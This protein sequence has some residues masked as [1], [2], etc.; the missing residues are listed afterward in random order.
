MPNSN[1]MAPNRSTPQQGSRYGRRFEPLTASLD[2]PR[3]NHEDSQ[4]PTKTMKTHFPNTRASTAQQSD[5]IC[6]YAGRHQL[7]M[8]RW[9]EECEAAATG[10]F[11]GNASSLQGVIC[12]APG[13][14]IRLQRS[15][16]TLYGCP[17][18]TYRRG[19]S[20]ISGH[21]E[22]D[23]QGRHSDGRRAPARLGAYRTLRPTREA[24][25]VGEGICN[26]A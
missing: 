5:A 18:G 23:L 9:L 7:E 11:K 14:A 15:I 21:L 8:S 22:A 13:T 12:A 2:S 3:I 19:A 4:T 17:Y 6:H 10:S 16:L 24:P 26:A 1:D 20:G 25:P